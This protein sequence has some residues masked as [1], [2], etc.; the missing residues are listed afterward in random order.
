MKPEYANRLSEADSQKFLREYAQYLL[1]TNT[2]PQRV[3]DAAGL[4]LRCVYEL[5]RR[6]SATVQTAIA[7][8]LRSVMAA[9]P[10]GLGGAPH[11]ATTRMLQ[12]Y[13][14]GGQAAVVDPE[15]ESKRIMRMRERAEAARAAHVAALARAHETKYGVPFGKTLAEMVA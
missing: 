13:L 1:D 3:A 6:N 4:S 8:A 11:E 9:K 10:R 5:L 14:E 15:F 2:V 7:D 12:T